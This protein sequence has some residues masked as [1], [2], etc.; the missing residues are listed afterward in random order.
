MHVVHQCEA[1]SRLGIDVD[2]YAK[3]TIAKPDE[4][5]RAILDTYGV[6]LERVRLRSFF[7]VR[8][9]ADNLRIALLV[10]LRLPS[11]VRADVVLSRNLYASFILAV[12]LRRS[13]VFETHQLERGIR[14]WMQRLVVATPNV[15]TVVIS[16][17]LR[18]R[19]GQHLR[20]SPKKTLVVHDAAPEGIRP[21]PYEEKR[22]RLRE[23]LP[24]VPVPEGKTVCGYFG[25]LYPGRGLEVVT[26]LAAAVPDMY[27]LVFG[28]NEADIAS[29]RARNTAPNL[30]VMGH[31]PHPLAQQIM[32]AVDVL[33]MPYQESVSIGVVGHDTA[34]WMSPMKMFEYM[35]SGTPLISSDLPVLREVL[36]DGVNSLLVPSADPSAWVQAVRRLIDD[37]GLARDIGRTAHQHYSAHHTWT[38]RGRRILDTLK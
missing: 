30:M 11:I 29:F 23:L 31:V 5:H 34:A 12:M 15:L 8:S 6:S 24:E 4:A 26:A 19:L 37:P 17:Q 13:L 1:F 32:A 36:C 16:E 14:R 25:H 18:L 9:W 7:G 2:L 22:E 10:L 28:G 3:R 35:A 38:S 27:I 33:L 20:V 21:I